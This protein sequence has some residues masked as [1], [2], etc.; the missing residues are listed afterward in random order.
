MITEFQSFWS[1]HPNLIADS[2]AKKWI[3]FRDNRSTYIPELH[4]VSQQC[5]A[6][7]ITY[8]I[9]WFL[10]ARP[11]K[12]GPSHAYHLH[13]HFSYD[14]YTFPISDLGCVERKSK[15]FVFGA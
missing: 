14:F 11:H 4:P 1:T 5:A 3:Y 13:A 9:Q 7:T 8:L 15:S 2:D 10:S 6:E 12:E